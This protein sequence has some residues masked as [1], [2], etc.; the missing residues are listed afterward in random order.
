[1]LL[2]LKYILVKQITS[3]VPC[4]FSDAAL[5]RFANS[6]LKVEGSLSPMVVRRI[7]SSSYESET[8][9]VVRGHFQYYAAVRARKLNPRDGESIGVFIIEGA[10][11]EALEE[12]LEILKMLD[13]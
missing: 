13:S 4:M 11:S 5:D 12:Q 3:D 1:M 10:K 9:I 8:Y 2:A 7:E 6:I